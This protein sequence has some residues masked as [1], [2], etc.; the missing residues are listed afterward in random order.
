MLLAVYSSSNFHVIFNEF[1]DEVFTYRFRYIIGLLVIFSYV[2]FL[3]EFSL[4]VEKALE[5]YKRGQDWQQN[6]PQTYVGE[7]RTHPFEVKI[8]TLEG[9]KVGKHSF[10]AFENDRDLGRKAKQQLVAY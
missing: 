9:F 10:R 6:T 5:V 8:T 7:H 4:V 1:V 2:C 3:A